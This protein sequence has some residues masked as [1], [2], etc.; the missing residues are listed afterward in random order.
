[1]VDHRDS[2]NNMIEK[3]KITIFVSVRLAFEPVR[4][5]VQGE[6]IRDLDSTTNHSNQHGRKMGHADSDD[7]DHHTHSMMNDRSTMD[8][9]RQR[10]QKRVKL[11]TAAAKA[12]E[13][14]TNGS[15]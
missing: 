12:L 8:I 14:K 9:Y 15:D 1:M 6:A 7:E 11:S 5:N 13:I 10:Q 3:E 2:T 4:V